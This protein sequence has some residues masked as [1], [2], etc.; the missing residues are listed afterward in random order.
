MCTL[1]VS[2][3]VFQVLNKL[4][5]FSVHCCSYLLQLS[6]EAV[7]SLI[8]QLAHLKH[9]HCVTLQVL[10]ERTRTPTVCYD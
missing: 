3:G 4:I 7:E 6:Q 10:R 5:I 9:G 8:R 1:V 2:L